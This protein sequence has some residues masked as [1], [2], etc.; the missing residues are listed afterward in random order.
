M[1]YL[2]QVLDDPDLDK[3]F[4]DITEAFKYLEDYVDSILIEQPELFE[5]DYDS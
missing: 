3:E 5:V 1:K 2:V 4:S